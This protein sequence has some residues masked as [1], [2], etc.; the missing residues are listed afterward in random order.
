MRWKGRR[1]SKNIEDRRGARGPAIAGGGIVV[2]IIVIIGGLMGVDL[3]PLLGG[4]GAGLQP[5][6]SGGAPVDPKND[7]R[8]QM[9]GVILADTEEVFAEMFREVGARYVEP[10]LVFFSGSIQSAC[11]FASAATGPFYCPAD[12]KVYIDLSFYD[13]LEGQLGA[14]GDF[15]QAYV[16]AHEVGHHAQNLLGSMERVNSARGRVSK[17]EQNQLSVRLELQADCYAG[18]WAKRAQHLT[19]A[20]RE[21]LKEALRAASAIGDDTLQ[22]RSQGYVVPDSFTHGTSD[23]RSRWF[24]RGWEDGSLRSCDTFNVSYSRL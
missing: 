16:I 20:D 5:A 4:G 2:V 21:D 18:A 1:Q 23:Q 15:A 13:Q 9:V 11:G 22:K 6:Q 14:G 12:S 17:E 7:E 19:E 10:T 3:T 8:A 24:M